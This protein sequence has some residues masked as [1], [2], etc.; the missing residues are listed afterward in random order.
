MKFKA[1]ITPE[2]DPEI[3]TYIVEANDRNE[4]I[5]KTIERFKTDPRVCDDHSWNVL[6]IPADS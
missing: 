2:K 5:S 6:V 3:I 1:T 4:A